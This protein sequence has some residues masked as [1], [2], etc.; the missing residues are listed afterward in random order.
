MLKGQWKDDLGH[1]GR[2]LC[3]FTMTEA[4]VNLAGLTARSSNGSQGMLQTELD[5]AV[6][7]EK[8]FSRC[9]N[10]CWDPKAKGLPALPLRMCHFSYRGALRFLLSCLACICGCAE[11]V[12]N[13]KWHGQALVKALMPEHGLLK[14]L[15]VDCLGQ[16]I[17][18]SV[19]RSSRINDTPQKL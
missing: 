10:G 8:Q 15:E 1:E 3:T 13:G 2:I 19:I 14:H 12:T 6:L 18:L 11:N 9:I 16:L 4:P 5:C 7:G 17:I